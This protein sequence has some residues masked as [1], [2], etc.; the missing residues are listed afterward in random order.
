MIASCGDDGNIIMWDAVTGQHTCTLR[1][2]TSGVTCVAFSKDGKRLV[3]GNYDGTIDLWDVND[4]TTPTAL[5]TLT[6][7]RL[8]V[9]SMQFSPDGFRIASASSDTAVMI[10]HAQSGELLHILEGNEGPALSVAWSPDGELVASGHSLGQIYLW[11]ADT[12]TQVG[13]PLESNLHGVKCVR[14]ANKTRGLLVSGNP[15]LGIKAWEIGQEGD[16]TSQRECQGRVVVGHY[17]NIIELSVIVMLTTSLARMNGIALSPD[18]R[19]IVSA[20]GLE[21][22]LR[23]WDVA[24]WQQVRKLEGPDGWS[25]DVAWSADGGCIVSGRRE[26]GVCVWKVEVQVC[27]CLCVCVCICI[28][29]DVGKVE[30]HS[31]V[32]V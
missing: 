29:K 20:N 24:T 9:H 32:H 8:L 1:G 11:K 12:G 5:Q 22:E 17:T 26:G 25:N 14:F 19:Y 30:M 7:H 16:V 15:D 10:W 4:G 21:P 31:C 28:Y 27:G 6:G 23:I 13:E 3:S 2:K 18:D